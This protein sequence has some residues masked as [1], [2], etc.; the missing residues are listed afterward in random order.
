MHLTPHLPKGWSS[1]KIHYRFRSTVYH[2]TIHR[3]APDSPHKKLR[4][5]DGQEISGE[6]IP[7]RDDGR[8]H[9]VEVRVRVE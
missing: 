8:E 4:S 5:L 7:L 2:I 3:L 6:T 9:A 1:F